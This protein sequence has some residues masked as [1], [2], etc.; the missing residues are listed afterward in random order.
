MT[1]AW[2]SLFLVLLKE[3]CQQ[4]GFGEED[5]FVQ[6]KE[7]M[8]RGVLLLDKRVRSLNDLIHLLPSGYRP[9]VNGDAAANGKVKHA[10]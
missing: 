6:F 5:W 4:D 2:D 9:S 1:G 7:H 3:R 8:N 10:V